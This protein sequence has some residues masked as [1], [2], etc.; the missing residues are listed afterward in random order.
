MPSTVPEVST[1]TAEAATAEPPAHGRATAP[2]AAAGPLSADVAVH[3][4]EGAGRPD[5]APNPEP[6]AIAGAPKPAA[7]KKPAYRRLVAILLAIVV[8]AGGF[9]VFEDYGTKAQESAA[10][11]RL[12]QAFATPGRAGNGRILG[13]VSVPGLGLRNTAVIDGA[14]RQTLQEGPAHD[15]SSQYPGQQGVVVIIGHHH[16]YGAPFGRL[17][18]LRVGDVVSLRTSS[19]LLIYRVT[20]NPQLLTS[21]PGAPFVLP[22]ASE[23]QASGGNPAHASQA[24]VLATSEGTGSSPLLVVVAT[25]YQ[26]TIGIPPPPRANVSAVLRAIPGD[27]IGLLWAAL[28]ILLL[29]GCLRLPRL[30]HRKFPPVAAYTVA[31]CATILVTYQLYLAIDRVLPGTS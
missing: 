30:R 19:G 25:L 31:A 17:G 29:V 10:Q 24:L 6:P 28:W 8:V 15:A 14:S 18:R 7:P 9:V 16:S 2:P 22:S 12:T 5:D 27:R 11:Q 4:D 20:R 21:R 23:V 1:P 26:S 3:E 13:L